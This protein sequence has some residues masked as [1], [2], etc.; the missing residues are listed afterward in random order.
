MKKSRTM[1][2]VLAA[3]LFAGIATAEK[4]TWANTVDCLLKG[5]GL[6]ND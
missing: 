6:N 3:M 4:F 1:L 5:M 2:F